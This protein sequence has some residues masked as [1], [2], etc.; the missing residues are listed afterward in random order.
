MKCGPLELLHVPGHCPGHVIFRLDDVIFV[1]DHV[2]N[3]I[4]PHQSPE[5][6]LPYLGIN[7]YLDSL[8]KLTDWAGDY[9]LVLSGHGVPIQDLQ[10]RIHSIQM[11]IQERLKQCLLFLNE[12]STLVELTNHLYPQISGYNALLV[13]EKTGAYVEYLFQKELSGNY[14]PD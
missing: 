8:S 3:D 14:Q 11:A 6:I 10:S 7:H 5:R 1:G 12:P 13:I 2:L 4:I 9:R